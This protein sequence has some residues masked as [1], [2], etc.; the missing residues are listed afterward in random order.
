MFSLACSGHVDLGDDGKGGGGSGGLAGG[1]NGG[2]GSGG[3]DGSVA[4]TGGS[5]SAGAGAVGSGG[6]S[7]PG[8]PLGSCES[9]EPEGWIAFDSDGSDFNRDIYRVR[10]DGSE[11]ERLTDDDS[12]DE[13]PS[14]SPDGSLIAFSSNRGGSMQIHLLD[15]ASGDITQLTDRA[16][17]ADQAS[18]SRDGSLVAFHSGASVFVI[19]V[20]GENERVIATGLDAFNAYSWPQF[21]ADDSELIFDRNNEINAA[22]LDGSGQ[23]QIVQNWT[24]TIKAPAVSP[25]GHDVAYEVHCDTV[26]SIWTTPAGV[27]T[28]PCKGRRVTPVGD[29]EAKQ[30]TWGPNQ[31]LAYERVDTATNISQLAVISRSA[32]SVPCALSPSTSSDRN[33]SWF[34]PAD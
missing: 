5:N 12:I 14:F 15:V 26:L 11:R 28:E 27:N 19:D 20:D 10:P 9:L 7:S 24:T 34:V 13:Q 21:S 22:R 33:P 3:N 17:G 29:L 23:R 30:A 32:D 1:S 4:G 8:A 18:F 25:N 2:N 31:L 6:S 16:E